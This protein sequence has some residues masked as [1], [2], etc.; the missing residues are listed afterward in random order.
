MPNTVAAA[1]V[2]GKN[3]VKPPNPLFLM[4]R[5]VNEI[6]SLRN[7]SLFLLNKSIVGYCGPP[8][9]IKK[10]N[11]GLILKNAKD[12]KQTAQLFLKIINSLLL[13]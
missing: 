3:T 2:K 7:V 10:L 11:S 5:H 1:T 4:V 9:S 12:E 6:Q 8:K 13:L